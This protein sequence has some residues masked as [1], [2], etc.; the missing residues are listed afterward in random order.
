[1]TLVLFEYALL[2]AVPRVDRGEFINVGAVLYCQGRDFLGCAVDL[3]PDRLLTL[4]PAADL[5]AVSAALDGICAVCEGRPAAGAAGAG[6]PRA[7]FGWLTA[8]RSTVIQAGPVHSGLTAD[9][10]VELGKV[11]RR[12]VG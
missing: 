9:P 5:D 4:D 11:L 8:P 7:R 6:S 1:V 12:L 3:V 2:R 10:A